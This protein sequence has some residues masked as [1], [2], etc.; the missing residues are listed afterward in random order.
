MV[1]PLDQGRSTTPA[2]L[3]P[4]SEREA[5]R[6]R[7]ATM[8]QEQ[9]DEEDLANARFEAARKSWF[10]TIDQIGKRYYESRLDNFNVSD[11]R[12]QVVVENLRKLV[13]RLPAHCAAGHSI[14]FLGP[15]GT[16]KDHLAVA[17]LYEAAKR[18]SMT[19]GWCD[20]QELFQEFRDRINDDKRELDKIR[21]LVRPDVLL[22]SDPIPQ[23]GAVTDFQQSI[24]S[25][26]I[27]RRYRELKPT[28][29]TMNVANREEAEKRLGA[30]TVDRLSEGAVNIVCNWGSYRKTVGKS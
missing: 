28:W 7:R 13:D 8:T 9:R 17:M 19:V 5:Y 15:M 12:Q 25:R 6:E 16:G 26:V 20:G 23:S 27:D 1:Q 22:I 18:H 14:A 10:K 3:S 2:R 30:Q 29:V 24:L 4:D 11:P 21:E